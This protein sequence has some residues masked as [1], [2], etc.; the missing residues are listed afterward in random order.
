MARKPSTFAAADG[1]LNQIARE[2]LEVF[3]ATHRKPGAR[4]L[5]SELETRVGS[6]ETPV[7]AAASE[8]VNAGYMIAPDADTL[9]LTDRGFDAIQR[10]H[11]PRVHGS[12]PTSGETGTAS[13]SAPE[14]SASPPLDPVEEASLESFPASDPPAWTGVIV[15]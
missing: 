3:G 1:E 10:A 4:M 8:L 14:I 7:V 12:P 2:I 15:G 6:A 13:R 9:E 5:L 11:Y